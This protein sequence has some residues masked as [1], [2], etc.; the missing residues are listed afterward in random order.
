MHTV[1]FERSD[2]DLA[3][4]IIRCTESDLEVLIALISPFPLRARPQV[5]LTAGGIATHLEAKVAPPGTALLLPS[6]AT[7]LANGAWKSVRDL[8][9]QVTEEGVAIRGVVTLEGLPSALQS[10]SIE[11]RS[12]H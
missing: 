10:L 5:T 11:C 6:E 9:L 2:P 3:G 7:A 1:S 4:L 12:Q 8:S